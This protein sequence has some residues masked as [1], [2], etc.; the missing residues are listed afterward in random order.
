MATS[1]TSPEAPAAAPAPQVIYMQAPPP[2]APARNSGLAL[3]GIIVGSVLIAAALFLGG[4]AIG[5]HIHP[6]ADRSHSQFGSGENG[7]GS[8]ENG[9]GPGQNGFAPGQDGQRHGGFPSG[10]NGNSGPGPVVPNPSQ[11]NN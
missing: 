4:L 5:L 6:G 2:A 3:A 11:T 1:D 8:G 7:F 10:P 9:F